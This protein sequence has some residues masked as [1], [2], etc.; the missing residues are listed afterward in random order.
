[1]KNISIS[2]HLSLLFPQELQIHSEIE[3]DVINPEVIGKQ[4]R[5]ACVNQRVEKQN[6]FFQSIERS[7]YKLS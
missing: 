1:M 6:D 5:K 4:A 2:L 3:K 7:N